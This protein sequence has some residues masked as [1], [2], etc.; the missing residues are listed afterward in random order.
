MN[1]EYVADS[2]V[3]SVYDGFVLLRVTEV[4]VHMNFQ[5]ASSRPKKQFKIIYNFQIS[6]SDIT[7]KYE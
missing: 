1:L 5:V 6:P 2:T 4:G 7:L 3:T